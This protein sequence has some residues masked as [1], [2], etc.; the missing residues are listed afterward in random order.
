MN[1]TIINEVIDEIVNEVAKDIELAKDIGLA[2]DIDV[3]IDNKII[4]RLPKPL[5]KLKINKVALH[6]ILI[7]NKN[8]DNHKIIFDAVNR[9]HQLYIHLCM[10]MRVFVLKKYH[11]NEEIPT[12]TK[13]FISM[14]I[15]ALLKPSICGPKPKGEN[16]ELFEEFTNFYVSDYEQLEY[17]AKIDGTNLSQI[18]AYIE[19]DVLKNIENNIKLHFINYVRRFVNASFKKDDNKLLRELNKKSKITVKDINN[20]LYEIKQDLLNNTLNSKPIYHKWIKR[21]RRYMFPSEYKDSYEFDCQHYPQ[22]YLKHM[23]YMCLELERLEA[24]SFQFFPI[25]TN[26]VPKYIPIDTASIVDLFIDENKNLYLNNIEEYKEEIWGKI[27]KTDK[28][29]FR[30]KQYTFDHRIMTDGFAVSIQLINKDSIAKEIEKKQAKKIANQQAKELYATLT[31]KEVDKLKKDKIKIKIEKKVQKDLS[32]KE[33][34]AAKKEAFKN[35]PKEEQLKQKEREK[36]ERFKRSQEM[37]IE[38]PYLEQL[39]NFEY[40]ELKNGNWAVIDPNLG[41]LLHIRNNKGKVLRYNNRHHLRKTKRIKYMRLTKNKRTKLG[42]TKAEDE[43]KSYNSKSCNYEIFK[44]YIKKKN[45]VNEIVLEKYKDAIFRQYKWYGYINRRRAED[46]LVKLIKKTFGE[47]VILIYG[48]WSKGESMKNNISTPNM[49][50]KKKLG[51]HFKIY[52]IDEFRTSCLHHET[53]DRCENL[54]LPDDKGVIRKLHS[55]LTSKMENKRLGCIN[56]DNN[57][58]RNMIKIVEQFLKDKTRPYIFRRTVKKEDIYNPPT[59]DRNLNFRFNDKI[60]ID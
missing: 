21:H 46:E 7:D 40:E 42:I 47:D 38:F 48:D 25:R 34:K 28:Q 4:K 13:D 5:S 45:E 11:A 29:V 8:F 49:E 60:I 26:I 44:Q 18:L 16:L 50:L 59:K 58:T 43:L 6:K 39:N 2:K 51:E 12:I 3:A 36:K 37:Y 15:K 31:Q 57:A 33:E 41:T 54:Y 24:K 30:Q 19:V 23:I 10:F 32:N 27:F 9:T 14:A 53:T 17:S 22:K 20:D 52:S 1:D 35:L 56:R 55:I